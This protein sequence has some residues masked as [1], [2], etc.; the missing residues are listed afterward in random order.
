MACHHGHRV[1]GA[2][3]ARSL[4]KSVYK[5][6]KPRT[7]SGT[8]VATGGPPVLQARPV[9]LIIVGRKDNNAGPQLLRLTVRRNGLKVSFLDFGTVWTAPKAPAELGGSTFPG[10][11]QSQVASGCKEVL[12]CGGRQRRHG[13]PIQRQLRRP[14]LRHFLYQPRGTERLHVVRDRR[15]RNPETSRQLRGCRRRAREHRR[16]RVPGGISQRPEN[17]FG[18][19]RARG[20]RTG[21]RPGRSSSTILF[22]EAASRATGKYRTETL[23]PRFV[24]RPPSPGV[25][26]RWDHVETVDL[27]ESDGRS[28]SSDESLARL[29][30]MRPEGSAHGSAP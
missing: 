28:R 15:L 7:L 20:W 16:N 10:R 30:R 6:K 12:H 3:N 9:A 1:S 27:V 25:E 19:H 11:N 23:R 26:R 24:F 8:G 14:S 18:V 21:S 22:G 4:G 29:R 5:T 13:I 2:G 17:R